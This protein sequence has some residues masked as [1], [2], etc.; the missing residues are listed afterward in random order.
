MK[1]EIQPDGVWYHGAN[2]IITELRVGS[3]II[4]WKE[5]AEAFSHQPSQLSYVPDERYVGEYYDR[6]YYGETW[7]TGL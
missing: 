2:R 3:T 6:I 1:I 5:L 4:Q 7:R